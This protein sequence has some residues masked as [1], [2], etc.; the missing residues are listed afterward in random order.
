[1]DIVDDKKKERK[2][3]KLMKNNTAFRD[4]GA[5]DRKAIDRP[6]ISYIS[7]N[8]KE[9]DLL[10]HINKNLFQLEQDVEFFSFA[11]KEIEEITKQ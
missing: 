9:E 7:L 5:I 2:N 3:R 6:L 1:M 10:G 4:Q 11:I 8:L